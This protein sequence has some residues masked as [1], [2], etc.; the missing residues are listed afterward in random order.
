M[1]QSV[2]VSLSQILHYGVEL[3]RFCSTETKR[4]WTVE[5]NME[6]L[7]PQIMPAIGWISS[8]DT[9]RRGC[10]DL[11]RAARKMKAY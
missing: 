1:F 10:G 2:D 3:V 5:E 8:S 4:Q 11:V 6:M 7:V 9:W